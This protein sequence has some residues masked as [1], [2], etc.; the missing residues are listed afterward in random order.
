[1]ILPLIF[2]FVV[3]VIITAPVSVA[4]GLAAAIAILWAGKA[5]INTVVTQMVSGMDSFPLMAIPF[6]I[7]AGELMERA[8]ISERLVHLAKVFVG[9]IRGGLGM[10]VLV[11]EYLF[12]GI[13]GSTASPVL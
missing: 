10:V 5:P 4:M 1:M 12:S 6:F 3:L 7:L 11:G 9:H 13:S 8:G 2:T